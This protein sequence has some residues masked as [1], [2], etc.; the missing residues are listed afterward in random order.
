[1]KKISGY[2]KIFLA[3]EGK[4]KFDGLKKHGFKTSSAKKSYTFEKSI[5][6]RKSIDRDRR[7]E[8]K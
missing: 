4:I 5:R 8:I 1:M 3:N 7:Y 6:E 2:Q